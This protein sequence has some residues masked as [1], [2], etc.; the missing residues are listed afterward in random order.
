MGYKPINVKKTWEITMGG[1]EQLSV[2]KVEIFFP[3]FSTIFNLELNH[4]K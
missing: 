2:L 1:Y 4:E 3:A